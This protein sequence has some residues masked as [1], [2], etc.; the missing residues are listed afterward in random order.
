M[1]KNLFTIAKQSFITK[2]FA[3]S[4]FLAESNVFIF[5]YTCVPTAKDR[6]FVG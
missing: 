6:N 5:V 1:N 2:S 3:E 4:N